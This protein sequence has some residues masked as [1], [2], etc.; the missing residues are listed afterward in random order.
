[1]QMKATKDFFI[2][3]SEVGLHDELGGGVVCVALARCDN[4]VPAS[5]SVLMNALRWNAIHSEVRRKLTFRS[6]K[7]SNY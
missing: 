7:P 5:V 2:L 1:M 3:D 6:L 4:S